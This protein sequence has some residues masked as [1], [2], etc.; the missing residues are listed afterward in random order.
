MPVK[1]RPAVDRFAEYVALA[2]S[3]CLQWLGGVTETGYG[4]FFVAK[5]P[6]KKFARAH[7]WSY[8]YHVGPIPTGLVL[9]HLCRNRAC[10]NPDHLEPVTQQVNVLR[11]ESPSATNAKTTHCPFGHPY[12]G[13][14]LYVTP[15]GCRACRE[16]KRQRDRRYRRDKA[17]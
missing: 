15:D 12:G 8:E 10:V 5:T 11:G 6:R 1:P 17:S 3:G 16:C 7:R 14:N 4:V 13:Q 2:P 9:D